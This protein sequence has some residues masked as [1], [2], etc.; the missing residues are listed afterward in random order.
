MV[1]HAIFEAGVESTKETGREGGLGDVFFGLANRIDREGQGAVFN[2]ERVAVVC[3][4]NFA[5]D[6][7]NKLML[8]L[9]GSGFEGFTVHQRLEF[10][11]TFLRLGCG[12]LSVF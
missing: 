12:W 10:R 2:G 1:N 5:A 6:V 3:G 11:G 9:A 4:A 8:T 7:P